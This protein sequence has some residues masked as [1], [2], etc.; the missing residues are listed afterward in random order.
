MSPSASHYGLPG[1]QCQVYHELAQIISGMRRHIPRSI[2][3]DLHLNMRALCCFART[4]SLQRRRGV[5]SAELAQYG[6]LGWS[7]IGELTAA[8]TLPD[9]LTT[10]GDDV[11]AQLD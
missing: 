5:E 3:K 11:Q 7:S 2:A 8:G 4:G 1:D 9:L 6:A 10:S